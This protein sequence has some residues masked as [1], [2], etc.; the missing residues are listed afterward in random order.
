MRR[1]YVFR[2]FIG[3]FFGYLGYLVGLYVS[4]D[5]ADC[6]VAPFTASGGIANTRTVKSSYVTVRMRVAAYCPCSS[7][8]GTYADGYTATGN[9]AKIRGIAANPKVYAYGVKLEVPG[10][11]GARVDDTG[12]A[13]RKYRNNI[14]VRF[15]THQQA[16]DWGVKYLD[17]KIWKGGG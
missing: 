11:G 6:A 9:S 2:I 7:C 12:A 16:L 15:P 14:E 13:V 17:V 3:L 8:C 1:M 10:Y 4:P 5:P